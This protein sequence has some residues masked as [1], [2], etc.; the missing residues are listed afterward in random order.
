[1]AKP[2][3]KIAIIGGGPIALFMFKRLI[4]SSK[5]NFEIEIF[6]RKM[7]LGAGMPYSSEGA[8]IEHITNVSGNE[9]PEIVTSVEEWIATADPLL[10]SPYNI[11]PEKFNDYKVLPRL[12]FGAYLSNQ[13]ELLQQIAANAHIPVKIHLGVNVTD[14]KDVPELDNVA[15]EV[16][17]DRSINF[18]K[19][20]LCTGHN[21]PKNNEGKTEN[22]FDSPY[23]PAKLARKVNNPIAIRGS[24]L[25]AV[26]AIRTLARNN[27]IFTEKADGML[28]YKVNADNTDFK[29]VMHTRSGM[30]PAV[31]FH[32]ED[33]HLQNKA[34][35]TQGE[36][37]RHRAKNNGFL[38][39]D[40]IF[41][42]DFKDLFK[43]N[44][45]DFHKLIKDM[46]IEEFVDLMMS[47]RE[48]AD[49]FKLLREEYAEAARSIKTHQS[50][51]WKEALAILSFAM[52][53]PA[54]HLSAEDM[55]R[56]QKVLMPLISIV[57]AFVPQTSCKELLA[58]HD[59]GKLEIVQVDAE[60]SIEPEM[61]GGAT[62]HYIDTEGEK[63]SVYYKMFVDCIGQPHLSYNDFPFESMRNDDTISEAL[64]PFRSAEKGKDA[65]AEGNKKV[66]DIDD[67]YYLKVPGIT[68]NDNF[69]VVNKDNVPNSRLYVMA[70]PYIGGYN[71]DYSGL[72]FGEEASGRVISGME[73]AKPLEMISE[74]L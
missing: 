51:Y 25:T 66:I 74:I 48:N 24:S 70:V 64:L 13:F 16:D 46:E 53:Y 28:A 18:N 37:D 32:L 33:S 72:D 49:P 61:K 21:W 12:L 58:L 47:K 60:S 10:L 34:L 5:S 35:L 54:K 38:S 4:E 29:I 3:E 2:T 8:N 67:N 20:I 17:G 19:V 45:A 39:L 65:E 30:L 9:I 6:E 52:N 44:H 22:Y 14:V 26:D 15:V 68:I 42:K 57:I 41:E 11:T 62:Y 73:S 71:P 1:M 56:L 7:Q 69:Q 36:I 50:V 43:E 55:I 27:G 23:P 31:R 59:A 40:F 63:Q